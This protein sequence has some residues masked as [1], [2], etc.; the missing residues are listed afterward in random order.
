MVT[1]HLVYQVSL[2]TVVR[3][4]ATLQCHYGL[5]IPGDI[6]HETAQQ[7]ALQHSSGA[8]KLKHRAVMLARNHLHYPYKRGAGDA[9]PGQV[10]VVEL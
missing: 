6:C 2:S 10:H 9:L 5:V 3:K 7:H 1:E 8:F 4:T